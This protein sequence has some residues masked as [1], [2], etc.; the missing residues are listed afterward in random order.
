MPQ[1][2]NEIYDRE[3]VKIKLPS[4]ENVGMKPLFPPPKL[5]RGTLLPRHSF[6]AAKAAGSVTGLD[7]S[8]PGP[9]F[10]S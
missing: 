2:E 8:P 5:G 4:V 6:K 10:H 9:R 3:F 7:I 1:V